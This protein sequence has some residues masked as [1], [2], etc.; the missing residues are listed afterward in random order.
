MNRLPRPELPEGWVVL[1]EDEDGEM[2]VWCPHNLLIIGP[3][4]AHKGNV[5]ISDQG[6]AIAIHLERLCLS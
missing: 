5:F 6:R 4:G 3:D 2:L 1:A